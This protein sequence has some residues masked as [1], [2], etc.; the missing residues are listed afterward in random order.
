MIRCFFIDDLPLIHEGAKNH[1]EESHH[2]IVLFSFVLLSVFE[3][4]W[5]LNP[6]SSVQISVIRVS[7]A[8]SFY[9]T[10]Q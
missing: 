1:K 2:L 5:R 8:N 6:S 10:A 9:L 4:S 3:P 7:I